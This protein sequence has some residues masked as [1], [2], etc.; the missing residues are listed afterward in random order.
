V[1]DF[2]IKRFVRPIDST[3]RHE[4]DEKQEVESKNSWSSFASCFPVLGCLFF[5]LVLKFN[6]AMRE[7]E[8]VDIQRKEG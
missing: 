5:L 8:N 4:E 7:V 2:S 6:F 3:G 1:C